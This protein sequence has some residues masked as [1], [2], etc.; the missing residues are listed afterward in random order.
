MTRENC[1]ARPFL[2]PLRGSE[3]VPFV[4][5]GERMLLVTIPQKS[6]RQLSTKTNVTTH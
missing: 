6:E 3:T 5:N 4:G 1:C 2:S